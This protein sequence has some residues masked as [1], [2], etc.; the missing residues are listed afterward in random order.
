MNIIIAGGINL[1]DPKLGLIFWTLVTFLVVVL[2]LRFSAWGPIM[3][4]LDE[5][6]SKITGDID[7]AAEDRAESEK[8]LKEAQ[9]NRT[10]IVVFLRSGFYI[11]AKVQQPALLLWR[12]P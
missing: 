8:L 7:K 10:S 5:R 2:I 1:I 11:P 6:E 3:K 9:K 12:F 4:A